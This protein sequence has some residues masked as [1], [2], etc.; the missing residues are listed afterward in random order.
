MREQIMATISEAADAGPASRLPAAV[1]G[2]LAALDPPLRP[3]EIRWAAA[4]TT[5]VD[6]GAW[7]LPGRLH[8]VVGSGRVVVAAAGPRP[9]VRVLSTADAA[10]EAYNHVT[11]ELVF[12][13]ATGVPGLGLHPLVAHD[14]L[15]CLVA[16]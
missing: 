10:R 16:A 5:T 15:G 9:F 14:L 8:V 13:D 1:T 12:P 4:T 3:A 6:T 11:G 7:L 2:L